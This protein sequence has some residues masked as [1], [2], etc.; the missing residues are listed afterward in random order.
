MKNLDKT[1]DMLYGY[2][3]ITIPDDFLIMV[4][5]SDVE[6]Q[7]E[8]EQ[9]AVTDTYVRE[10]MANAVAKQL[11]IKV[12][13]ANLWGKVDSYEWPCYGDSDAYSEEFYRQLNDKLTAIGGELQK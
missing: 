2:F 4:I 3:G 5:N 7:E 8:V 12:P 6:L 13:I 10:I 1:Q 11:D 9:G